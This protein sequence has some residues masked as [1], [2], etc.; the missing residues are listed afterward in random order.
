[1]TIDGRRVGQTPVRVPELSPGDHK[2]LI[3]L[4]GHRPVSSTVKVVAGEQTR[5]AVTLEQ[6]G[7]GRTNSRQA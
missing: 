5:L 6:V 4:T 7:P 2:V 1:M 3:E